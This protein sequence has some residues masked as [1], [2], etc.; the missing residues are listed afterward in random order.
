MKNL[1]ATLLLISSLS[2]F[3]QI[4]LPDA[5]F[6]VNGIASIDLGGNDDFYD[7]KVLPDGKILCVVKYAASGTTQYY[8]AVCRV[9]PDGSLDASYGTNGF[10][11]L[12]DQVYLQ[13]QYFQMDI[14]DQNRAVV[15]A[16]V[17]QAIIVYRLTTSGVLDTDFSFDGQVTVEFSLEDEPL[18]D[19]EI[20]ADGKIVVAASSDE[21][22]TAARLNAD[23]TFDNSFGSNGKQSHGVQGM[24]RAED[25]VI[26]PD[27][28]ILI[29]GQ[30][31]DGFGNWVGIIRMNVDGTLDTS[32]DDDGKQVKVINSNERAY[33]IELQS[34]GKILVFGRTSLSTL[35]Q[36]GIILRY[37]TDGSE[38]N[39]FDSDGLLEVNFSGL[40]DWLTIGIVQPD[41]KI[42]AGGFYDFNNTDIPIWVTRASE[43]GVFDT[44]FSTDGSTTVSLS[45]IDLYTRA[46]DFAPNGDLII[47]AGDSENA[48]D[49]DIRLVKIKTGLNI[50]INDLEEKIVSV[51]PNPTNDVLNLNLSEFDAGRK[52][53]RVF[54][55]SG[56]LV[57]E[58]AANSTNSQVD[59]TDLSKGIY[60]CVVL[61]E[62][63]SA[64]V[65][66]SKN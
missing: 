5:N 55:G 6:G 34:D 64:T 39:T 37:N 33:A 52:V 4:G 51:Y 12:P 45:G 7:L 29:C 24:E 56:K 3:G 46:L 21:G 36:K 35:D 25:M 48:D 49:K 11:V 42:L 23:G 10:V 61:S 13:D 41:D 15:A 31:D 30:T 26:Q 62:T 47:G 18:A 54:D 57:L 27:G 43:D 66:F 50:G 59:L 38:D 63:E 2:A 40:A 14:D 9:N 20:Q 60:T 32:F 1:F 17:E 44:D 65:Q 16:S 22:F 8:T 58:S 28:K 19:V 53:I